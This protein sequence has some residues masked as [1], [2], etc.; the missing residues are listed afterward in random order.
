MKNLVFLFIFMF[1]ATNGAQAYIDSQF[2][3]TEQA[4][5]NQ[6]FSKEAARIVDC[7]KIDPYSP[8]EDKDDR[9]IYE[10]FYNYI[11]PLS[12]SKY[13]FPNSDIRMDSTW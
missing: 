11:N 6:G 10:K 4:L 9:T 12:G 3:S 1:A 7:K 2:T 8:I 13:T 5:V